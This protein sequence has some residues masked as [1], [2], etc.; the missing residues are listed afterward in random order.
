MQTCALC[1]TS[2]HDYATHC[3]NCRADLSEHSFTAVTLKRLQA[4]PRVRAVRIS[5]AADG[6]SYCADQLRVYPKEQVPR[7]PHPGCSHPQ[8]C[9]CF[10]E[11]VLEQIFP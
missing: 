3:P 8:G 10:Y 4:N 2:T 11:P 9:R 1:N 7:L 5:V 6:C